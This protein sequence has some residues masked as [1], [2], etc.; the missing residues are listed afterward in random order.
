MR[1]ILFVISFFLLPIE[2]H[3][4][5][6]DILDI[7]KCPG[8]TKQL[9]RTT[10]QTAPNPSTAVTLNPANVSF[11][12]GL[13]LEA[14]AHPSNPTAFGL[15]SGTGKM[16]GALISGSLENGFFGNRVPELD[17]DFLERNADNKRYR[18]D[19]FSFAYG[20]KLVTKQ[21]NVGLDAGIIFK[22][23]PK[24]KDINS[25][26]GFSGRL[27][28]IHFG[29][30]AYQDDYYLDLKG[31]LNPITGSLYATEF[32]KDNFE[33]KF[34]VTTY[35]LGTRVGNFAFDYANIRS[36]IDY[37]QEPSSVRIFSAAYNYKNILFNLASRTETSNAPSYNFK[38]NIL[39]VKKDKS[40][41]YFAVQY[42]FN[43]HFILGLHYNYY[44]LDEA[45][46]SF[47]LFI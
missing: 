10:F 17:A 4:D 41:T 45:G 3:A 29:V 24:I 39:E 16:G 46:I 14:F 32:G 37:Y 38:E 44:L 47:T 30:S 11:D 13:G 8:V 9:R 2:V 5:I 20:V 42:S 7:P 34:T 6:C 31:K 26:L 1:L 28:F 40:D 18:N 12:R 22:R 33:E 25:G 15:I 21:K 27:Y 36:D 19:K 43:R 23:H 35:T